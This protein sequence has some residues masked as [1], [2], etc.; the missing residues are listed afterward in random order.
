MCNVRVSFAFLT[1]GSIDCCCAGGL[2]LEADGHNSQLR[3]RHCLGR[4][5]VI[6]KMLDFGAGC[7]RV[8]R[9]SCHND[10]N[11]GTVLDALQGSENTQTVG[12]TAF[13]LASDLTGKGP[14]LV[15][16]KVLSNH[17]PVPSLLFCQRVELRQQLNCVLTRWIAVNVF[18][19]CNDGELFSGHVPFLVPLSG[20]ER[21]KL[22]VLASAARM[23]RL[24]MEC[25]DV[26]HRCAVLACTNVGR[27]LMI[28]EPLSDGCKA[29]QVAIVY[30]ATEV[31][32]VVVVSTQW[33]ADAR[34]G[35]TPIVQGV[36]TRRFVEDG[37]MY[38]DVKE[39]D[40]ALVM[41]R[42]TCVQFVPL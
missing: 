3:D 29:D 7:S 16:S 17:D 20:E 14:R 30:N 23:L 6:V 39:M 24:S 5:D 22:A 37:V 27:K 28:N 8:F 1:P 21:T 4:Q 33:H 40:T 13:E 19:C 15:I 36:V 35:Q 9:V 26:L 12:F 32:D 25:E 34:R 38:F 11:V 18:V 10:A 2:S 31:G 42:L 41:E